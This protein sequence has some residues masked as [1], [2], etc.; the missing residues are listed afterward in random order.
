MQR[1][2]ILSKSGFMATVSMRSGQPG[3]A[4]LV[5]CFEHC[6]RTEHRQTREELAELSARF[7][8]DFFCHQKYTNFISWLQRSTGSILLVAE[9][10]EVKPIMDKLDKGSHKPEL[11]MCVVTRGQKMYH[12]ACQWSKSQSGRANI[13]V[14]L[15]F[16]RQMVEELITHRLVA[17]SPAPSEVSG[18]RS[19]ADEA[20]AESD[21]DDDDDDDASAWCWPA[22]PECP[23]PF[24]WVSL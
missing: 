11:R 10:R 5:W 20:E 18:G 6:Y 8:F 24:H 22:Q 9:W 3:T 1:G 21:D 4:S 17:V 7:G 19:S 16:S 15:G 14:S 12:R 2:V 13:V 23:E